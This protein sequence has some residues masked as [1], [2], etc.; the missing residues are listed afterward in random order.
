MEGRL[1]VSVVATGMDAPSTAAA[2]RPQAFEVIRGGADKQRSAFV[3]PAF[4]P[5]TFAPPSE[6]EENPAVEYQELP[7]EM[8]EQAQAV[9]PATAA[10]ETAAPPRLSIDAGV[11]IPPNS[12][13]PAE[14]PKR[15]FTLFERLTGAA[16]R[17]G[18]DE[19]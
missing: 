6:A 10:P 5:P 15:S 16:R 12:A 9:P 18:R 13:R 7:P 3:P 8:F 11:Y 2:Q 4:A 17:E 14:P 19:D 1:R